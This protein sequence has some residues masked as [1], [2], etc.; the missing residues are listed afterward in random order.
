MQFSLLDRFQRTCT[1]L[2]RPRAERND[3]LSSWE[4]LFFYY[5][6]DAISFTP[7][8]SQG[9]DSRL[10]RTCENVVAAAPPPCSPESIYV[11][12]KL[13]RQPSAERLRHETDASN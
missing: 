2:P 4:S 11:L 3:E 5:C 12:A 1:L 9:V 6:T 13:V 10:N 7:L 8:K